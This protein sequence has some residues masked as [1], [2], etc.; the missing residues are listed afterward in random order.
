[1]ALAL[2]LVAAPTFAQ[3]R[4]TGQVIGTVKDA[5]GAVVPDADVE[6]TDIGTGVVATA[7]SS[8]EGGFAFPALQPGHYRL[9]ATAGGFQPTVLADADVNK[10]TALQHVVSV[11]GTTTVR[12]STVSDGPRTRTGARTVSVSGR[13][14]TRVRYSQ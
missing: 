8:K 5:S 10:I 4:T 14:I 12:Y 6:V 7:K 9:L 3:V 13:W 2:L 1:M 11:S